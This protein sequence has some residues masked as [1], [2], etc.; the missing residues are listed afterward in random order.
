MAGDPQVAVKWPDEG[1]CADCSVAFVMAS[2]FAHGR[3]PS[4]CRN[5][6]AKG[7]G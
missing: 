7:V 3:T 4:L 1:P 6:V 5:C 2:L